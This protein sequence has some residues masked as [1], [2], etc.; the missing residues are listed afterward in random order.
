MLTFREVTFSK[1]QNSTFTGVHN[2]IRFLLPIPHSLQTDLHLTIKLTLMRKQL[3]FAALA[4]ACLFSNNVFAKI[5]RV[6]NNAGINANFTTLQAAHD[7]AAS[8]DTLYVEGSSQ[9]YGSLTC[10]KKLCIIGPGYY[11]NENPG[12]QALGLTAQSASLDFGAGSAGSEL[13]GMNVA[14]NPVVCQSMRR[15]SLFAETFLH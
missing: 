15:M 10:S 4:C 1:V 9:T 3:F 2:L 12:N 8:G 14:S 5:W 13:M 6:N 11:L 7:G